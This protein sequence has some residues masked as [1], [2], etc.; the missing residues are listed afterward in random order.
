MRKVLLIVSYLHEDII[1][2]GVELAKKILKY[3]QI[4]FQEIRVLDTA[5]IPGAANILLDSVEYDGIICL[6]CVIPQ[7]TDL[8]D[9]TKDIFILGMNNISMQYTIP[10]SYGIVS[11]VNAKLAKARAEEYARRA[12][13]SCIQL[14]S[15]KGKING[16]ML[17][18]DIHNDDDEEN[19]GE[20]ENYD[21]EDTGNFGGLQN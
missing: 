2:P 11:A 13:E 6:G 16:E 4:K 21:G 18:D 15:I 20:F 1:T 3:H 10:L 17:Q 7:E 12:V 19:E 9:W 5:D 14:M 8:H